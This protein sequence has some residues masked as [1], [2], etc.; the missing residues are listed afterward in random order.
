MIGEEFPY[1]KLFGEL[2]KSDYRFVATSPSGGIAPENV[3]DNAQIAV[4]LGN[5][6]R[7]LPKD[8]EALCDEIVTVPIENTVESLNVATAGAVVLYGIKRSRI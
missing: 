7:G 6:P 8:V 5:E 3:A 1:E 4:I 2:K